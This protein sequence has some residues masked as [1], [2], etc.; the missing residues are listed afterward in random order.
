MHIDTISIQDSLAWAT[1][2][3]TSVGKSVRWSAGL[4]IQADNTVA[5]STAKTFVDGDVGVVANTITITGHGF[6]TGRKV[7]ATSDGTLPA[8]LALTNYWVIRVDADTIKL[9][10]SAADSLAGTPVDITA[11]AGGGTHTLTPAALVGAA[12]SFEW[13]PDDVN[14]YPL[15]G[16][17][18]NVT[19]TGKL[20]WQFPAYFAWIRAVAV[21]TTGQVTTAITC[22]AMKYRGP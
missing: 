13:S 20:G 18:Q 1:N 10:A 14:W 6:A 7:A 15:A 9:A 4:S 3:F 8:G 2:G 21:A 17:S 19:T 22:Y 16:T 5:A 12:I 11:A